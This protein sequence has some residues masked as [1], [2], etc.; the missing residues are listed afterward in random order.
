MC[1]FNKFF[2]K[3]TDPIK[4]E[5]SAFPLP[6]VCVCVCVCVCVSI[7]TAACR[8]VLK[9]DNLH[10]AHVYLSWIMKVKPQSGCQLAPH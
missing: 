10:P 5:L 9:R 2:K 4:N 7:L 8:C 1:A 6:G 3:E